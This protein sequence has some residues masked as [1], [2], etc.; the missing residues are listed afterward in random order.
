MS[1]IFSYYQIKKVMFK[2][3]IVMTPMVRYEMIL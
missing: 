1:N 2:N 3:R